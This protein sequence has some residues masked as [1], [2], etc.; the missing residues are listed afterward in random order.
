MTCAC[1][2]AIGRVTVPSGR[3][4]IPMMAAAFTAALKSA[5]IHIFPV[6]H[7]YNSVVEP[8]LNVIQIDILRIDCDAVSVPFIHTFTLWMQED[9]IKHMGKHSQDALQSLLREHGPNIKVCVHVPD[10]QRDVQ[11]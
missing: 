2:S 1:D 8:Q 7:S 6:G 4:V 11:G 9:A 5:G 3:E 10:V